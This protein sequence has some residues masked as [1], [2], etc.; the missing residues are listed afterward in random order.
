MNELLTRDWEKIEP[1][2][3]DSAHNEEWLIECGNL[4]ATGLYS[5]DTL[6][7]LYDVEEVR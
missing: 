6:V 2:G 1:R 3:G 4:R 7:E 5:L